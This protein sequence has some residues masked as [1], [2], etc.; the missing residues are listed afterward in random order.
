[1]PTAVEAV[2]AAVRTVKADHVLTTKSGHTRDQRP[3]NTAGC[4]CGATFQ[5][6]LRLAEYTDHVETMQAE[7]AVDA[8]LAPLED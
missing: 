7:A 2:L 3:A 5:W 6:D 1:M 8:C 4:S